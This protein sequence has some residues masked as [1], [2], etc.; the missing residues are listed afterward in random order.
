MSGKTVQFVISDALVATKPDMLFSDCL[1]V[2]T[3][4][5]I[6]LEPGKPNRINLTIHN[7]SLLGRIAH[8]S[9]TF[10]SRL[11]SVHLPDSTFYVGP[12]G[13]TVVYAVVTPLAPSGTSSVSF[14]VN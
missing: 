4:N 10:D 2:E 3:S 7:T 5:K 14:S 1:R 13:K 8:I 6:V 12:E 9:A 11:L